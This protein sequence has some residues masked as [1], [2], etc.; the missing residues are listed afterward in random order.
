MGFQV[1]AGAQP[2]GLPFKHL[3][4]VGNGPHPKPQMGGNRRKT[5]HSQTEVDLPDMDMHFILMDDLLSTML[6]DSFILAIQA[7]SKGGKCPHRKPQMGG[8][9]KKLFKSQKEADLCDMDMRWM[10]L[11]NLLSVDGNFN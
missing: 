11:D 4:K 8:N 1:R 2:D 6:V 10:Q 3:R 5:F 9:R 7:S